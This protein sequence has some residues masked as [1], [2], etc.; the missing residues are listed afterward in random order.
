MYAVTC[1]LSMAAGRVQG[2]DGIDLTTDGPEASRQ[3][4][5]VYPSF[6][7]KLSDKSEYRKPFAPDLPLDP[8]QHPAE[9]A[10]VLSQWISRHGG[11]GVAR[12]CYLGC[13]GK[14]ATY[15]PDRLIGA[16]NM[17]D[18]LPAEAVPLSSDLSSDLLATRDDCVA[19]F[20]KHPASAHRDSVLDALGRVGKPSLPKKV[21]HRVS[22]I[23]GKL[24][25]RFPDLRFVATVAV[26]CRNHFVHGSN[27]GIA[28]PRIE[29]LV[30]FLTDALE[31]IF[32]ASDF[33]DAGWNA[34][35]WNAIPHA[36]GHT[37]ARFRLGYHKGLAELR[38]AT[39]R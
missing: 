38:R 30:P 34:Q 31:F 1:F 19:M 5:T 17:F 23:D 11:R 18:I 14:A 27:S 4:L 32:A 15:S 13:M 20:K 39:E 9:F 33:I 21:A 16:A 10:V 37:F 2:I 25:G 29:S 22:I 6:P 28:Y 8:I 35:R 36:T 24:G 7:A 26:Q 3:S 12:S